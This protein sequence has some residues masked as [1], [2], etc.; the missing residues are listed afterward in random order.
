MKF[1]YHF[2]LDSEPGRDDLKLRLRVRW[3]GLLVSFGVRYRVEAG[4]WSRE[5]Q[6][7]KNSTSHGSYK[8]SASVINREIQRLEMAVVDCFSA[9]DVS[10]VIPSRHQF[11]SDFNIAIGRMPTAPVVS[12]FTV[13]DD[14]IRSSG[15][16]NSWSV[17]MHQKFATFR[18][19]LFAF[20]PDLSFNDLTDFV[21]TD[22]VNYLIKAKLRNV[23]IDKNIKMLRWFL[24]WSYSGGFYSGRLHETFRPR[25]KGADGSKEVIHLTWD[26]L[27]LFLDF[28][29]FGIIKTEDSETVLEK[30]KA[31]ALSRVRDVFCFCCF[32]GLRYSDVAK[33]SRDDIRGGSIYVVTQK[34]ADAL[35]IELNDF[36]TAILKKWDHV[37]F[38]LRRALPV[39][40]NQKMNDQLKVAAMYAGLDSNQ[41]I[42]YF[43]GSTRFEDVFPLHAVIS[44]HCGRRTFIVNAFYLG[45]PAE[46]IMRWTGHK[47][48]S[49][50]KP[51][52]K[53]VDN[54]KARE[55]AKFKRPIDS[56]GT[57]SGD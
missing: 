18:G 30:S 45:I 15:Q 20:N 37:A 24:R 11:R 57:T 49:S 16:L 7:C 33:L 34:T 19:H 8:I 27:L 50:M 40:S 56:L 54:L 28:D 36:S 25:L 43:K 35:K 17:S 5:T 55:M 4:K 41:R 47:N 10:G 51:Y 29:F 44:T 46:V 9:Y 3:S 31:D 53:I 22:F 52:I 13:F 1:S 12:L 14:F 42:V 38:P 39:I 32:T 26:E 21:L 6:R 23:S 2:L 48:Y